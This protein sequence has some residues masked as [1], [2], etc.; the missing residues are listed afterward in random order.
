MVA[1]HTGDPKL[2]TRVMKSYPLAKG[3]NVKNCILKWYDLFPPTKHNLD[4]PHGSEYDFH[5][6][7]MVKNSIPH[8]THKVTESTHW[9]VLQTRREYDVSHHQCVGVRV[10]W[11]PMAYF[12]IA[13]IL[14]RKSVR[15]YMLTTC[16]VK[17]G[18]G[19]HGTPTPTCTIMNKE[20]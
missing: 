1:S 17:V 19:T 18:K 20:Y 11:I 3:L 15:H 4:L 8:P 10:S 6:M 16:Q 14:P 7:D 13:F 2:L 9:G 5:Q 12:K